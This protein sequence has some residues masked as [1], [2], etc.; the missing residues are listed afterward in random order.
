MTGE[1]RVDAGFVT[2]DQL[3]NAQF[4]L[5]MRAQLR[6]CLER[7]VSA[8]R[9]RS[10][11][12]N[13]IDLAGTERLQQWKED[14][15]CFSDAG[16]CLCEQI[17]ARGGGSPHLFHQLLLATAN[18]SMRKLPGADLCANACAPGFFSYSPV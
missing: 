13:S 16:G 8:R 3:E 5:R 2:R 7:N 10:Q 1:H 12:E 4:V 11:I 14:T 17:C 9:F 18:F 6:Q 15:E